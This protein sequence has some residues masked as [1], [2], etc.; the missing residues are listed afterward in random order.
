MVSATDRTHAGRLTA[1]LRRELALEPARVRFIARIAAGATIVTTIAMLFRIPLPAY[2]AYLV[3]LISREDAPSTLVTAVGGLFAA[4]VA[5]A[6]SIL[7]YVFDAGEPAVRIPV[8]VLSTFVAS[9]LSRIPKLGSVA[10]PAGFVLVLT[11]TLADQTAHTEVLT[12]SLLWLWVVVAVP[13]AVAAL[14]ALC[15]PKTGR[16]SPRQTG[17]DPDPNGA[18]IRSNDAFVS[19]THAWFAL[20]VTCA[21]LASYL[22]YALLDWPGIRTAVTTCFF[23]SLGT[24]GERVHKLRLRMTGALM[25]GLLAGLCIVFVLPQLTDIGQ[26]CVIVIA[27]SAFCAWISTSSETIAYAGMQMAFA[28]FLGVMQNYGPAYDLT[29]LRD[30]VVGIAV[31]NIWMSVMFTTLWPNTR[32]CADRGAHPIR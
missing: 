23:V 26:L 15:C 7:L 31:G 19:R 20:K 3:F 1:L 13:A 29:V 10:R 24:V 17:P 5:V 28:F 25:G 30:R 22:T 18:S 27:V 9:Y 4:T 32:S 11:Q 8:L 6:A 21:V 16:H 2:M 14:L 12:R